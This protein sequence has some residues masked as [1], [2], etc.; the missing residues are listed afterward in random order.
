[1]N[2]KFSFLFQF[3]YPFLYL[4][5]FFFISQYIKNISDNH[6]V[7]YFLFVAI[8]ICMIDIMSNIVSSQARDIVNMKTSGVIEEIIFFDSNAYSTLFAMSAYTVVIS[9]IKFIIYIL[10]ISIFHEGFIIPLENLFLFV[11]TFLSLVFSF[12]CIGMI[13]GAYALRFHK[14]GFIPAGFMVASIVFGS[15]YFPSDILP[16]YIQKFSYLIPF[17]FGIENMRL[18]FNQDVNFLAPFVNIFYILFLSVIFY[19]VGLIFM[20]ASINQIK[21]SGSFDK[22]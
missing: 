19:I 17:S 1:M 20:K 22:F 14:I 11:V 18:L 16:S 7:D 13:G 6:D 2:F 4:S 8:G 12:V 9:I 15:A 10:L 5:I 21:K 3:I